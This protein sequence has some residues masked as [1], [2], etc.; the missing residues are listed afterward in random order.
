MESQEDLIDSI[1]ACELLGVTKTNLRQLVFRKALRPVSK[2]KKR[3]T[4]KRSD[5]ETLKLSRSV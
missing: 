3:S 4:F 2:Y 5:I 1:T